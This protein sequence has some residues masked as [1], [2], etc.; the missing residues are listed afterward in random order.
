MTVKR[1]TDGQCLQR[2]GRVLRA[3]CW[4]NPIS[5]VK[6]LKELARRFRG[7]EDGGELNSVMVQG[8][9]RREFDKAGEKKRLMIP[10]IRV[11]FKR[12]SIG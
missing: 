11:S 4:E 12:Y 2:E 1:F 6:E 3:E 8:Q 5:Q 9:L 7:G 10:K